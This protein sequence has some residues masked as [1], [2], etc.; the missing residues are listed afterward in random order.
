MI[1]AKD[2]ILHLLSEGPADS[3]QISEH[4]KTDRSTVLYHLKAL[5][6][7]G[8]ARMIRPS[9]NRTPGLYDLAPGCVVNKPEPAIKFLRPIYIDGQRVRNAF[10]DSLFGRAA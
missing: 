5:L 8:K 1:S 6:A 3:A 9:T 2:R 10:E 4:T 7:A